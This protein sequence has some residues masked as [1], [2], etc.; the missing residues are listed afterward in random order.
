MSPSLHQQVN[1][2]FESYASAL[3]KFDT[4]SM[5]HH[6]SMPCT[7]LSDDTCTVFTDISKLEGLFVQGTTFYKQ[8]G[9]AYSEPEV[10]SKQFWTDKTVLTRVVWRYYDSERNPIYSCDY[11]YILRRDKFDIFR[12]DVSVAINEK[13][14]M[15]AWLS[16][17]KS[18]KVKG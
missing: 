8:F 15:E 5:A 1:E 14:R 9:I 12:I 2:F 4:K 11:Q 6:Y 3:E 18:D 16:K 17:R 13:E 10:Y 7:F